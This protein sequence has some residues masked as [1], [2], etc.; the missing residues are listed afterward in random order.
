MTD[1]SPRV[2]AT[3]GNS[4]ATARPTVHAAA[5]AEVVADALAEHFACAPSDVFDELLVTCEG[6]GTQRWLAHRLTRRLGVSAGIAMPGFRPWLRATVC[7]AAGIDADTDPWHPDRLI[8]HVLAEINHADRWAGTSLA[9]WQSGPAPG[10]PVWLARHATDLLLDYAQRRPELLQRWSQGDDNGVPAELAWQPMLWRALQSQ[11]VTS[12][13]LDPVARIEPARRALAGAA[14]E[15]VPSDVHLW[16]PGP[17]TATEIDLL[18]ALAIRHG[19]HLWLPGLADGRAHPLLEGQDRESAFTFDRLAAAGLPV[20]PLPPPH[21]DR[22]TL[23]DRLRDDLSAG[24]PGHPEQLAGSDDSISLHSCHGSERQAEVLRD[25][26]CGLLD[27]DPTLEPRDILVAVADPALFP[28]LEAAL[29]PVDLP[30]HP[31][32]PARRL[33]VRFADPALR[34]HNALLG[35]LVDA[36]RLGRGRAEASRLLSFLAADP[37][38]R[39]FGLDE[40]GTS[41]VA[42]LV[43]RAGVRWGMN[44]AHRSRFSLDGLN[45]NTWLAGLNRMLVGVAMSEEGSHALRS[46]LP[47]DDVGSSDIEVIG[48]VAELMARL[49]RLAR[50]AGTAHPPAEWARIC[51]DAIEGLMTPDPD[52]AWQLDHA[53]EVLAAIVDAAPVDAPP[54]GADDLLT[55]LEEAARG[56]LPRS[57]FRS[58]AIT[59]CSLWPARHVPHR[60]VCVVGLDDGLLPRPERVDGDN[61]IDLQPCPDEPGPRHHDRQQFLDLVRSARQHLV[62]LWTGADP[63]TG[64]HR[65]PASVVAELLDHLDSVVELPDGQTPATAL[66]AHHPLQPYAPAAFGDPDR[67]PYRASAL[68]GFDPSSAAAATTLLQTT[69][70]RVAG[71]DGPLAQR[72][73]VPDW[74]WEGDVAPL[75]EVLDVMAHPARTFLRRRAGF[76][77]WSDRDETPD[78]IPLEMDGLDVWNVGNRVLQATLRGDLLEDALRAEQLRGALPPSAAGRDALATVRGSVDRILREAAPLCAEAPVTRHVRVPLPSGLVLNADITLRGRAVVSI[79]YGRIGPRHRLL[80]WFDLLALAAVGGPDR[81]RAHLIGRNDHVRLSAPDPGTAVFLLDRWVQIATAGLTTP[82]PLPLKTGSLLAASVRP[83]T[84]GSE[85]WGHRQLSREWRQECDPNWQL[86]WGPDLAGLVRAERPST[87]PAI[88]DESSWMADLARGLWAPIEQAENLA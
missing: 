41:R 61:I 59:V 75:A 81:P 78:A 88:G 35:C 55:L 51:R 70:S 34:D 3:M 32:H 49:I 44:L 40:D 27:D 12:T 15:G 48:A 31:G 87:L 58:G 62:L 28:V 24:S 54:V 29:M 26:L 39:R 60:V 37:V 83:G 57:A 72:L 5:D 67:A 10:Q 4:A 66:V 30:G 45:A 73:D 23:L 18:G 86:L 47:L 33:P 38:A 43:T 16:A 68:S 14:V 69:P 25:V 9:T 8:W 17:L 71:P 20:E 13:V 21:S 64:E 1:P 74:S 11:P 76:T 50:E 82:L 80:G 6:P 56:R 84:D 52:Q 53:W 7:R 63:R 79:A 65:P 42:D 85:L 2:V 22:R 19:V 77:L 46:A 36:L